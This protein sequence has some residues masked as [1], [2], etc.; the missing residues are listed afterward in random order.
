MRNLAPASVAETPAFKEVKQGL[1]YSTL[2]QCQLF[3]NER[4]WRM[5]LARC[6]CPAMICSNFARRAN[7]LRQLGVVNSAAPA[8]VF[9]TG[10][11]AAFVELP[12]DSS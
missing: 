4:L 8:D 10:L 3:V 2:E 7:V 9:G 11:I 1:F 6:A 5:D 12:S